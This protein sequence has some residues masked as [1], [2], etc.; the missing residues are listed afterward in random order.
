MQF[1]LYLTPQV[2]GPDE[3][4]PSIDAMVEHAHQGDEAGFA[5][6]YLTEH[7]F[8]NYNAYCDPILMGSRLAPYLE[9]AW[10]SYSVILLPLAHPFSMV[11]DFNTIDQ[12]MQGRCIFGLGSAGGGLIMTDGLGRTRPSAS[13]N[14]SEHVIEVMLQSWRF[15]AGDPRLEVETVYDRG[16]LERPIAPSSYRRPHPLLARGTNDAA[17]IEKCGRMGWPVMYGRGDVPAAERF[18]KLYTSALE[19]GDHSAD[20]VAFC[21]QWMAV[22]KLIYVGE[23]E[24]AAQRDGLAMLQP[25]LGQIGFLRVPPVPRRRGSDPVTDNTPVF[26]QTER[27]YFGN[28]KQDV[29][30]NIALIGSPDTVANK[31]REY[32]A[33]GMQHIRCWFI[34]GAHCDFLKAQRSFE[35][36]TREVMPRL[37]PEPIRQ[38]SAAV[39]ATA[40]SRWTA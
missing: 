21:K 10:M 30:Q 4:A 38:P 15:Q 14:A 2:E 33:I 13:R 1:G 3:D 25:Y 40:A 22:T 24:E 28:S 19:A 34:F 18:V 23:T 5:S 6:V 11:E 37:K 7:H 36:F 32:E 12:L 29:L 26:L 39:T 35:L 16:R 8:D 31:L 9:R 20:L 27:I 17:T